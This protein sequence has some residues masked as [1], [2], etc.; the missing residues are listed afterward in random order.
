M[1]A[2][3]LRDQPFAAIAV[4]AP[5]AAQ[6]NCDARLRGVPAAV[7]EPEPRRPHRDLGKRGDG[8][9]MARGPIKNRKNTS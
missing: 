8:L 2:S 4:G 5:G 3:A 1:S 6:L 9:S 7:D